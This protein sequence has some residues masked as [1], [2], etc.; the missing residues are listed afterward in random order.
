ME[1]NLKYKL[2]FIIKV[3]RKL[4]NLSQQKLSNSVNYNQ[5][6]ISK[7]ERGNDSIHISIYDL[8]LKYFNLSYVYDSEIDHRV[9]QL[10][11]DVYDAFL[12]LKYDNLNVLIKKTYELQKEN[13]NVI[14]MYELLILELVLRFINREYNKC[15]D[16]INNL[17]YFYPVCHQ[18]CQLCFIYLSNYFKIYLE[19]KKINIIKFNKKYQ[20]NQTDGF[21]DYFNGWCYYYEFNYSK[22]LSYLYQA[23]DKFLQKGN[24]ARMIR[25]E[26]MI[27]EIL[28]IDKHYLDVFNRT[29]RIINQ[30]KIIELSED[31]SRLF[32]HLGYSTYYLKKYE[33]AKSYF[34]RIINDNTSKEYSFTNYMYLKCLLK[35]GKNINL[36]FVNDL[37]EKKENIFTILFFKELEK[38]HFF[39]L[40]ETYIIPDIKQQ[41]FKT[42]YQYYT[43]LLLDHYW[44]TKKYRQYK[45]LNEDIYK[46]LH[47]L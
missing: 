29:K 26:L 46:I 14:R 7:I 47:L 32:F 28:L 19:G 39:H 16:M 10:I 4:K 9:N 17:T 37:D 6:V 22:A 42:E 40:I 5:S 25:C 27:N 44:N 34:E 43:F 36:D 11:D 24:I 18:K 13:Q 20:L 33:Q 3:N 12:Y 21:V 30:Y 38:D 8:L 35:I 31:Y 45:K 2:G 41:I 15:R 1:S 23:V